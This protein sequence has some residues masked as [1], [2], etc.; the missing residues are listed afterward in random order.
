MNEPVYIFL[1]TVLAIFLGVFLAIW[2]ARFWLW[3]KKLLIKK[4][5][6][7]SVSEDLHKILKLSE[8]VD[9]RVKGMELKLVDFAQRLLEAENEI[10]NLKQQRSKK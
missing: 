6:E 4:K 8:D 5:I 1:R 2:A 7:K 10:K 3:V 9:A